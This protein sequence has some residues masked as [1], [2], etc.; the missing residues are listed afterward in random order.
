MPTTDLVPVTDADAERARLD[1]EAA[2]LGR[3]LDIFEQ[4]RHR[5]LA[6]APPSSEFGPLVAG[7]LS[8]QHDLLLD[9]RLEVEAVKDRVLIVAVAGATAPAAGDAEH[10]EEPAFVP[11]VDL[12]GWLAR[13]EA[14]RDANR[15]T[16]TIIRVPATRCEGWCDQACPPSELIEVEEDGHTIRLCPACAE[17]L[18]GANRLAGA[19]AKTITAR[20]K[21][22]RPRKPAPK[23]APRNGNGATTP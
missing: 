18:A 9:W 12:G 11:A 1:H 2:V 19:R 8:E 21:R 7:K 14:I 23:P 16:V 22:Q 15:A 13:M 20:P 6:S 3:M 4:A 5:V 17:R 10:G